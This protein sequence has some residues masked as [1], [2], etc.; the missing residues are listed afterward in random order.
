[1]NQI[2]SALNN[3]FLCRKIKK[4]CQ[5]I[6]HNPIPG[7]KPYFNRDKIT[8]RT[9]TNPK[10]VITPC[11]QQSNEVENVTSEIPIQNDNNE[12]ND[13]GVN[14]DIPNLDCLLDTYKQ[15]AVDDNKLMDS[16]SSDKDSDADEEKERKIMKKEPTKEKKVK[17]TIRNKHQQARE[18]KTSNILLP[19]LEVSHYFSKILRTGG[20]GIPHFQNKDFSREYIFKLSNNIIC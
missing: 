5:K 3:C 19:V 9:R 15:Q 13:S 1:M 16:D 4:Y 2:F 6:V 8:F 12:E 14:N 7:N 18:R 11:D 17:L 20:G 10:V